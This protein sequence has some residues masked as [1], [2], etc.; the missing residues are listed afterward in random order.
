MIP[1]FL[2]TLIDHLAWPLGYQNYVTAQ[3]GPGWHRGRFGADRVHFMRKAPGAKRVPKLKAVK[4][5]S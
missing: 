3:G 5:W 2:V 1:W 4:L